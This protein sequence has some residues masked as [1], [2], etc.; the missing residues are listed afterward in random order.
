MLYAEHDENGNIVGIK[1]TPSEP[2]QEQLTD[3]ELIHFFSQGGD[4]DSYET[5]LTLLDTRIIRVLDD[6]I[7]LL[8][9]KN[10]IMFT[11]LPEEAREKI[12]ERKK[13]RK[14]LHNQTQLMV[15]D[16]I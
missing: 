13:V 10:V 3:K 16:I 5:L 12:G 4:M 14:R 6:L 2:D 15:D 7:D 1:K 8:V 9:K 11:E